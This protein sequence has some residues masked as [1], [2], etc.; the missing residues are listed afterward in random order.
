MDR[1]LTHDEAQE[2]LGAYAVHAL[3]PDE[4]SDVDEHLGSCDTCMTELEHLLDASAA[5]GMTDLKPPSAGLWD[6]IRTDVLAD[7]P[8]T[9][10]AV[11]DIIRL[12]AAREH[13]REGQS[14]WR[15]AAVSAAAAAAIAIP[16]TLAFS[17]SSS[18]SL[19]ALAKSAA[20][21]PNA[22]TVP[23]VDAKGNKLAEAVMTASGQGYVRDSRLPG[24]PDGQTYQLWFIDN[25]VPVSSG[26]LGRSPHVAAFAAR[27]D[28]DAIAISVEPANGSVSPSTSPVAVGNLT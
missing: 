25:G 24:L 22:R 1:L 15:I 19:A 4:R 28:V 9:G 12:D 6:R 3:E 26:L 8:T 11:A 2:L 20:S 14:R 18:P 21:Q 27:P 5:L 10:D 7:S 13:R 16:T 17:G 23:L